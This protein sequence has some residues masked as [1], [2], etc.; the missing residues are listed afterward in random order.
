M[1]NKLYAHMT[2]IEKIE[3]VQQLLHMYNFDSLDR[4]VKSS[5]DSDEVTIGSLIE[6]DGPTVEELAI[7][8]VKKDKLIKIVETLPPRGQVVLKLRFGLYDGDERT[9]EEVGTIFNVT[10]ERI[11]QVER[12]ALDKLKKQLAKLNIKSYSD[13]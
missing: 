11:R 6:Y 8:N 3:Y 13:L 1:S 5:D 12:K 7:K 2:S 4:L 10:R 9:L